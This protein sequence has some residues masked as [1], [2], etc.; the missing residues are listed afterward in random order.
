MITPCTPS[1]ES[2]RRVWA[3][4]R[5]GSKQPVQ[6]E[7]VYEDQTVLV[8][9]CAH[10]A[11]SS[12]V[13]RNLDYVLNRRGRGPHADRA[14]YPPRCIQNG[15]CVEDHLMIAARGHTDGSLPR[16]RQ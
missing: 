11:R 5:R 1:Y 4:N 2:R 8:Q 9:E 13:F 12:S 14:E 7:A 10:R 3:E 15:C 6:I 16:S